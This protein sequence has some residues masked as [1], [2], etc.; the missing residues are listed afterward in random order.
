VK[1]I[2]TQNPLSSDAIRLVAKALDAQI[3]SPWLRESARENGERG[4]GTETREHRSPLP[5][6]WIVRGTARRVAFCKTIETRCSCW[7][8]ASGLAPA[9]LYAAGFAV[10]A[11]AAADQ[12]HGR[13]VSDPH[14][15]ASIFAPPPARRG[16]LTPHM[17]V[18]I[19]RR[20]V[21]NAG[22]NVEF[23]TPCQVRCAVPFISADG[24][25]DRFSGSCVHIGERAL[26]RIHV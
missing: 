5:E 7:S 8:A 9:A 12:G 1:Q 22:D 20:D 4:G 6:T 2:R 18:T 11:A 13:G 10:R 14:L 15:A 19:V 3:R 26:H 16:S 23:A 21:S 17:H 25:S 24:A